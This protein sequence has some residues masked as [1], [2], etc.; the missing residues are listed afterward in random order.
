MHMESRTSDS[1]SESGIV[2]T[3]TLVTH[4]LCNLCA[5]LLINIYYYARM[6]SNSSWP[7]HYPPPVPNQELSPSGAC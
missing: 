4:E 3:V 5:G 2:A 1:G 6:N 7:E